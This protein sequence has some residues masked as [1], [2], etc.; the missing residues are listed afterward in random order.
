MSPTASPD[1]HETTPETHGLLMRD[2][3]ANRRLEITPVAPSANMSAKSSFLPRLSLSRGDGPVLPLHRRT[4][5]SVRRTPSEYDLSELSPRA[6]DSLLSPQQRRSPSPPVRYS[7]GASDAG[8][9]SKSKPNQNPRIMFAGPP[10]PIAT[11]RMLYRDEE[12]QDTSL[13][14]PRSL[15]SSF[16]H[17][18][19]GVLFDRRPSPQNHPRDR[20]YDLEPDAIWLNLHRRE[21]AL[22][23]ELQHLLDAQSAGLAAHFD[24]APNSSV[25][26]TNDT[27]ISS[28]SSSARRRVSFQPPDSTTSISSIS[29]S[30]SSSTTIPAP[31]PPPGAVLPVRQPRP[32]PPS[33]R[34][35]R[36][37]LA[38]TVAQLADLKAEED[39]QLTQALGARKRALAQLRQ[40]AARREGIAAELAAALEDED[41]GEGEGGEGDDDNGNG[42]G[43][44]KPGPLG[45]ELRELVAERDAVA[46]EIGELEARLEGLRRRRR[47][48]DAR[49]EEVRSRREAELSG[50]RGALREVEARICGLLSRPRVKPLEVAGFRLPAPA[51]GEGAAG[52]PESAGG[53]EFL[54][55]RPERRTVEMARDW[56]EGEVAI[57][58]RRRAEVNRERE[59]L[60]EGA[61]VWKEVVRLVSDFETAL[62]REMSGGAGGEG[63]VVQRKKSSSKSKGKGKEKES[64]PTAPTPPPPSS[65]PP[66]EQA[67][68][69]QLDKMRAVMA[70][71]EERL[72][73]AEE[74]GWNLLICAIGAELEAFRLAEDMLL[75]ALR[76]A[77]FDVGGPGREDGEE[78]GQEPSPPQGGITRS[79]TFGNA[80]L[81]AASAGPVA[82]AASTGGGAGE[83]GGGHQLV[84]LHDGDGPG[85]G[86]RDLDR[87]DE[88]DNEVPPDLLVAA[89]EEEDGPGR[90]SLGRR[91]SENEVPLEFLV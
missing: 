50:Y 81:S 87:A 18:I 74:K 14:S 15:K 7:D 66:P 30:T 69:A 70:G 21:R 46:G 36:A 53:V 5:S 4:N 35:A 26:P 85:G 64:D 41:E 65:P 49:V 55:L 86:G 11:S 75:D 90:P 8:S 25:A 29:G 91:E 43:V 72:R 39:A 63:G 16:V 24:P 13:G 28:S 33:L 89:A 42:N 58:E 12:D 17:N 44:N 2:P 73:L 37:G 22:Q 23:R 88:S 76:A 61:E 9:A 80:G 10:P 40:L 51:A 19:S 47:W 79:S 56:W 57:L 78:D 32:K 38:R 82:N 60:E 3:V 67:M 83:G 20:D 31:P 48:L 84:N 54:R 71:L 27:T 45:R 6:D 52:P 1:L 34:A 59:A 68:F 77:G 62:R